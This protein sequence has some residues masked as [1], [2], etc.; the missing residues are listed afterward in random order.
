MKDTQLVYLILAK[1]FSEYD[2]ILLLKK[3]IA[4]SKKEDEEIKKFIK[5]IEVKDEHK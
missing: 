2:E 3:I 1:V 5:K 4:L